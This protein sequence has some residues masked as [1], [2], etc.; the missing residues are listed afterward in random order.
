MRDDGHGDY[1]GR[2]DPIPG[3]GYPYPSDTV[4]GTQTGDVTFYD[5]E[6]N[7]S[8]DHAG[9]IVGWGTDPDPKSGLTGDLTDQHTSNRF[10]SIWHLRPYNA[11][12]ATTA[13]YVRRPK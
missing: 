6:N 10:H 5:W 2:W 11:Q 8:K 1:I 13:I 4:S 12:W 9:I 3:S 7:G